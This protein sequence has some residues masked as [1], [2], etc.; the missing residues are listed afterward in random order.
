MRTQ[1]TIPFRAVAQLG[2]APGSGRAR[3]KYAHVLPTAL[4]CFFIGKSPESRVSQVFSNA[5][6]NF[7][8]WTKTWTKLRSSRDGPSRAPTELSAFTRPN[9]QSG[10]D[11]RWYPLR[12]RPLIAIAGPRRNFSMY[13]RLKAQA[14]NKSHS[15]L[16]RG[17]LSCARITKRLPSSRCASAIQIV[18]RRCRA[19]RLSSNF[20]TGFDCQM[21]NDARTIPSVTSAHVLR[22]FSSK[23]REVP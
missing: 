19:P 14:D 1:S 2:K 9:N 23:D 22:P 16:P 13:L 4:T 21:A 20:A 6:K 11:R 15:Q 10:E 7:G 3:E 17:Q 12:E 18:R 8:R 5:R